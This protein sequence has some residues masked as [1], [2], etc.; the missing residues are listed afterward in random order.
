VGISLK[1]VSF[2]CVLKKVTFGG[3]FCLFWVKLIKGIIEKC[4]KEEKPLRNL[5]QNSES[6]NIIWVIFLFNSFIQ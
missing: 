6:N 2:V 5:I 1:V 4:R 3:V